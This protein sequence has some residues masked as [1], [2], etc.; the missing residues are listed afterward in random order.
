MNLGQGVKTVTNQPG[1]DWVH[2]QYESVSENH[3]FLYLFFFHNN[4]RPLTL[5]LSILTFTKV[6]VED[7][8][9]DEEITGRQIYKRSGQKWIKEQQL[10]WFCTGSW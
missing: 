10:H 3:W 2:K 8:D 4:F 9:N 6:L 7:K 1:M 5:N